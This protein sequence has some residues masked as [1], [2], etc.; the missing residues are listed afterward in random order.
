MEIF[1]Q[2]TANNIAL[3]DYP[4]LK[5]LAM[6]AYLMEN[7]DILK[8]DTENFA[9]VTVLDAEIA[10]RG[11]RKTS[12]RDGRID[13]LAKYG[14]DYLALIELKINEIN[15]FSLNQLED[16]LDERHQILTKY[17]EFWSEVENSP[18]WVGVLVG[19]SISPELQRKLQ[20]G[21]TTKEGIPIAGMILRR[22]RSANNEIFVITDTFFKYNY[23]SRDFSKFE[24]KEEIYNK[25]RLVNKVVRTY[26]EENPTISFAE[27]EKVFPQSLQG[28]NGV[29]DTKEKAQEIYDRTGHKRHYLKSDELIKL[30]DSI[31]AT[32]NQWGLDNIT[33]FIHHI[34]NLNNDY[35]IENK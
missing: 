2:I 18:N 13:I 9:E 15:E 11:G 27:L 10:L 24:F 12:N 29:F 8:L 7:E 22:F 5:E 32:S 3:K 21:Y 33:R 30:S 17:P 31:I 25:A 19:S 34:N 20:D 1:R 16:Y 14:L 23:T 26:V 6:E 35:S 28:S 4:F